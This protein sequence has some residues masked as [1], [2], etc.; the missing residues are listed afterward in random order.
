[1]DFGGWDSHASY[2]TCV[3]TGRASGGRWV[4]KQ[5][6]IDGLAR[7][8]RSK[9][10]CSG[11]TVR[12]FIPKLGIGTQNGSGSRYLERMLTVSGTCR[13]QKRSV[14]EYLVSAR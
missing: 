5:S 9:S 7:L 14:Y 2:Q 6:A 8:N 10:L 1:M 11:V 4:G 12:E 3:S 13:L